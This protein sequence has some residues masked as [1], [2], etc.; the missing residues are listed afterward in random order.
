M[1][2]QRLFH[3]DDFMKASNGEPLRSV[4]T[5]SADATVV[6]WLVLPG[7]RIAAHLHPH[8]QDT[9]TILNGHGDYQLDAE[10]NCQRVVAGD[11]VV[12]PTGAVHGVFNPGPDALRFVS[13]VAPA[14]AGYEPL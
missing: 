12:A 8:G 1:S 13:V 4:I 3:S 11:V 6:A 7:Q 5:E 2:T 14:D 10:G 9:W